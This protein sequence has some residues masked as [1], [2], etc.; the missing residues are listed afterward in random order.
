M[1]EIRAPYIKARSARCR[2]VL[3]WYRNSTTADV[4]VRLHD[5]PR[6]PV[7]DGGLADFATRLPRRYSQAPQ[8]GSEPP[9]AA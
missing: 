7:I 2:A 8:H 3:R 1:P 4:L 5:E 6:W 9:T